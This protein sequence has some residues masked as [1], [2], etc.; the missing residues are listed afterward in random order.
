MSALSL[1]IEA[2]Q[3]YRTAAALQRLRRGLEDR[4]QLHAAVAV[5]WR[6]NTAKYLRGL[7]RH[8]TAQRLGAQ[9]TNHYE[10][11]SDSIEGFQDDQRAGIRM[12][13]STGLGRAFGDLHIRPGSGKKFLTIPAHRRTYGRRVGDFDAGFFAYRLHGRRHAALVFAKQGDPDFGAVA[14]W[15]RTSVTI[16]Q[17]RTLLPSD[18]AFQGW[19]V[20]AIR[21]HVRA[22]ARLTA[23]EG[24]AA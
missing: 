4:K 11:A 9:P 18:D 23:Q 22:I 1:T 6:R 17:D 8:K 16:K 20:N 14:Y 12:P 15:L 7:N 5:S 10:R 13:R 19:A 24:G 2:S 3:I 21:R